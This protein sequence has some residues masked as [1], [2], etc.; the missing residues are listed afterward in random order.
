MYS[1]D[2]K[3]V[4]V[5]VI[6]WLLMNRNEKTGQDLQVTVFVHSSPEVFLIGNGVVQNK[7]MLYIHCKIHSLQ[8]D[9][10]DECK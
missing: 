4:A 9:D 2:S 5:F 8:V 3:A 10:D 6:H 7:Y 1:L